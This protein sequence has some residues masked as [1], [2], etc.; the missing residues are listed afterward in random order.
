MSSFCHLSEE[1]YEKRGYLS[2]EFRLFHLTQ[3]VRA[4]IAYHYHDFDKAVVFLGGASGY[5]IEGT[6]Y[7]LEPYDIVLVP[8]YSIHRPEI[9]PGAPYSRL[10]LYLSPEFLASEEGG[11]GKL[12]RLFSSAGETSS[13]VLRLPSMKNSLLFESL[14]RL[15]KACSEQGFC[16]VLLRRL[17]LMEFLIY[18][19]RAAL[20]GEAVP[21]TAVCPNAAVLS[22]MRLICENP[23]ADF[24]I[25][26][27]ASRVFLSRSHMMRL[28]KRETGCTL[29]EYI[30]EKRLLMARALLDSG[31]SVTETCYRCGFKNYS[32][33]LRA[34]KKSFGS[35]PGRRKL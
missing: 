25:D 29:M 26:A 20:S 4:P 19:S 3:P 23:A 17:L 22:L 7:T 2:E 31:L 14:L 24:S 35:P 5:S 30:N 18:L 34:Y 21:L 33:F 15:E 10:I 12:S 28:F 32:A 27:L 16:D 11:G 1:E 9:E 6:S 13:Y 8:H